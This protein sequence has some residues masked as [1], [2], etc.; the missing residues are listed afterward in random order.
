LWALCTERKAKENRRW[1]FNMLLLTE[2][3]GKKE[4]PSSSKGRGLMRVTERQR[5]TGEVKTNEK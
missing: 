5:A 1:K 4:K 2:D 3:E